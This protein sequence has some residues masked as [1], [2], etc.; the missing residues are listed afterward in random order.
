MRSNLQERTATGQLATQKGGEIQLADVWHVVTRYHKL[1]LLTSV[2]GLL[3]GILVDNLSPRLYTATATVELN[4]DQSGGLNFQDF[5]GAA[6]Q[7]GIGQDFMTDMLTQQAIL[8]NDNTALS[9]I[10]LL[11][12]M[13]VSPYNKLLEG[14]GRV[15]ALSGNAANLDL[16]PVLRDQALG[17][18]RSSLRV[19]PVKNT[20]LMKVSFTDTDPARAA[21]IANTTVDAYLDNHTEAR[22]KATVKASSWLITQLVDLK[23]RA[24][25]THRRVTQYE[26]ENSLVG[27]P[28]T[29]SASR[30]S[31][32]VI[33]DSGLIAYQQ[34]SALST[35]LTKAQVALIGKEAIYRLTQTGDPG[36]ILDVSDTSLGS[37]GGAIN[38]ISSTSRNIQLIQSLRAQESSLKLRLAAA[39][40]QYGV[41]NPIVI[42]IQKQIESTRSQLSDEV[43]RVNNQARSDY[44]LAKAN[45]ESLSKT[46]ADRQRDVATL[47]SSLAE[48]GFLQEEENSSRV[49]YQD[50]YNRLEEAR[51]AAGV[52]SSGVSTVDPA[53][54]P[55]RLSSPS[56]KKDAI[57]G[58]VAGMF[59]GLIIAS[60][61][62]FA[63][64]SLR[65]LEEIEVLSSYPLLGVVP[66]FASAP[67]SPLQ[68][69]GTEQPQDA[70]EISSKP[71]ILTEPKSVI[72]EAYRQIRTSILLSNV[73]ATPHV[74]LFT[75]ALS[76]E[77]KST[78][79]YNLAAAF[80]GQAESVI[81]VDA[82]MRRPSVARYTG[83]SNQ[84]GLSNLLSPNLALDDALQTHPD[85]PN[86]FILPAGTVPPN[87]SEMLASE[88]FAKLVQLLRERFEYVLIDAPPVLLVADPLLIESHVDGTIG[89]IRSG[90]ITSPMLQR[91]WESLEK[92]GKP[93]LGYVF[94]DYNHRN[95]SYGVYYGY[96]AND[97]GYFEG[98]GQNS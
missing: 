66:H 65:T 43:K 8:A 4:K 34:L 41:A 44:M 94:N 38:A 17:I 98:T 73:D 93:I 70:G 63:D 48:L 90:K 82:D 83:L 68:Q 50:L 22:Y 27:V 78:T 76:G 84:K 30:P 51:I 28:S 33:S 7:L 92:P 80:A 20:R 1:I 62:R 19:T 87:P 36:V 23:K 95:E 79:A 56:L 52:K 96:G 46:V 25:E 67:N 3:L 88:R 40:V 24:E 77:G 61:I 18:F 74:L 89:V 37:D 5:S 47:G 60:L 16:N 6:S 32:S 14:H 69:K 31:A 81:L 11:G 12:L 54:A 10:G 2:I 26:K 64:R 72:A 45:E 15:P 57:S 39:Q 86:L 97:G 59:I 21:L 55:S 13:R 91:L 42:Q 85:I 75:S 53:R 58:L 35:E 71:W 9:V 29:Q 49:I